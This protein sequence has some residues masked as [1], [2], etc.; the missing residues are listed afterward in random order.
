MEKWSCTI[1][2][3]PISKKNSQRIGYRRARS[4][5]MAPFVLPS[6]DYKRYERDAG[7]FIQQPAEPI[8]EP[9]NVKAVYYMPTRHRV[10]LVNLEE[11]TLDVL[12]HYG[13]LADDNAA[14]VASMDGSRVIFGDKEPRVEIE[15]RTYE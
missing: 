11:A 4:G 9:C 6:E 14:I 2:G 3:R 12:V 7:W 15:V 5:D 8:N 13:V 10:D 1:K